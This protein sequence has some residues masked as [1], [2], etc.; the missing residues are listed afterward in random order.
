MKQVTYLFLTLILFAFTLSS[1]KK[2][3]N[4][5]QTAAEN[6]S[7]KFNG[8][9]VSSPMPIATYYKSQNSLQ[10]IG[11]FGTT[12]A[13]SLIIANGVQVG[14]FDLSNGDALL[15]YSTGANLQDTYIGT[16]GNIVISTLT[17]TTVAGT[18]QFTATDLSN[19]TG[20]ITEGKFTAK[21]IT[22]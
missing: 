21:L 3:S 17:S 7:L 6:I 22:Q 1:C 10:I 18:F 2:S 11:A 20:T 8:T 13:V 14:T 12:S 19:L 16:A 9:L 15:T 4:N 5:P